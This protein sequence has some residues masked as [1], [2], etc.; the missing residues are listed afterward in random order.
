MEPSKLFA[1]YNHDQITSF[2]AAHHPKIYQTMLDYSDNEFGQREKFNSLVDKYLILPIDQYSDFDSVKKDYHAYCNELIEIFTLYSALVAN[3]MGDEAPSEKCL[4]N[5][6]RFALLFL[7]KVNKLDLE[8]QKGLRKEER[9]KI[10]R[11]YNFITLLN[12]PNDIRRFGHLRLLWELGRIGEAFISLIK[13]HIGSGENYCYNALIKY[14]ADAGYHDLTSSLVDNLVEVERNS[15]RSK[16]N[17]ENRKD[18]FC[19]GDLKKAEHLLREEAMN[20]RKDYY[21]A[22]PTGIG[23][24]L[25]QKIRDTSWIEVSKDVVPPKLFGFRYNKYGTRIFADRESNSI[26]RYKIYNPYEFQALFTTPIIA[27]VTQCSTG[28]I[29]VLHYNEE[30]TFATRVNASNCTQGNAEVLFGCFYFKIMYPPEKDIYKE[31]NSYKVPNDKDFDS[32]KYFLKESD[33]ITTFLCA[34]PIKPY[35]YYVFRNDW[36]ELSVCSFDGNHLSNIS[37]HLPTS[38]KVIDDTLSTSSTPLEKLF[39]TEK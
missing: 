29:Y 30:A 14:L 9:P 4:N 38:A 28:N 1:D 7:S 3:I 15:D 10:L 24:S 22:T 26:N 21:T 5:I 37:F 18:E 11:A 23:R 33:M 35:H 27:C 13:P 36:K 12:I 19:K 34:H 16:P 32:S 25:Q 2:T 8:M 39:T 20:Q 31:D 6:D 17:S